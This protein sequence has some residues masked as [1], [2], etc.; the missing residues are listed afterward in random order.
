MVENK[1][2]TK[3]DTGES[4]NDNNSYSALNKAIVKTD[5]EKANEAV[6]SL[7]IINFTSS[8]WKNAIRN[9]CVIGVKAMI[10][11]VSSEDMVNKIILK[12]F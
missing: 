12:E 4:T 1:E 8:E 6:P 5:V 2:L 3:L 10:H 9:T 11:Y 7:V